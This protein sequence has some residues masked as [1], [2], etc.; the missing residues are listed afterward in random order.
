VAWAAASCTQAKSDRLE[1]GAG[2]RLR[3]QRDPLKRAGASSIDVLLQIDL[4]RMSSEKFS[5]PQPLPL[6][7][8]QRFFQ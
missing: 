7:G 6:H 2:L 1:N 4:G 3:H 8:W 5:Q